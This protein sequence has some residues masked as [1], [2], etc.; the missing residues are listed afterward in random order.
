MTSTAEATDRQR[1]LRD[2]RSDGYMRINARRL[3][4]LASLDLP[5]RDRSVLELGAG[6]GD[7]TGFFLDRGCTVRSL[8]GREANA[9]IYRERFALDQ[10]ASVEVH[11]LN[12][13]PA[14]AEA[15]DVVFCYGLLYH[16]SDPTRCIAWMAEKARDMIL[17]STC[18]TPDGAEGLCP[19]HEDAE[20]HSQALD[21]H[22]C[23]PSRRW[24]YGQL[25][26]H[27]P[28]VYTTHSQPNHDEFPLDWGT[29]S[30]SATG[31][32]RAVFVASRTPLEL[33][34]LRIGLH[35]T[36]TRAH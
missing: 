23:R 29:P 15:A 4:H 24:V 5:L 31:L 3:E 18:V 10:C 32:H 28:Y 27:M 36:H 14:S 12:A 1:V 9:A 25:S 33:P 6:V 20:F 8:E 11:D 34:S 19:T 13:P 35:D 26:R 16:L 21:G 7:L 22:A 17:L 30:A 2:F